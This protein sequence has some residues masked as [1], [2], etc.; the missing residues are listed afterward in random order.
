MISKLERDRDTLFQD[1]VKTARDYRFHNQFEH[2]HIVQV[3]IPPGQKY[4]I[5]ARDIAQLEV[6]WIKVVD[7]ELVAD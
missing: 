1:L 7:T 6:F 2:D 3:K 4:L 5:N